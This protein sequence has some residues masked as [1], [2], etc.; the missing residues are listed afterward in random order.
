MERENLIRVSLSYPASKMLRKYSYQACTFVILT[1]PSSAL[2]FGQ[3]RILSPI[4]GLRFGMNQHA[5]QL[6]NFLAEAAFHS[7]LDVVH[8]R[9]RQVVEHG[10]VQ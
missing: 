5:E 2:C 4:V 7:G 3:G 9:E 6:G 10:A 8:A 1:D